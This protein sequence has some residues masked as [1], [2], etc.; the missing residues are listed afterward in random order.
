MNFT[1]GIS[2]AE[3]SHVCSLGAVAIFCLRSPAEF[4]NVGWVQ[5]NQLLRRNGHAWKY[6]LYHRRHR[7]GAV[8]LGLFRIAL[9]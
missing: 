4:E 1:G 8:Y 7:R 6:F 9:I 5:E 2:I 3:I